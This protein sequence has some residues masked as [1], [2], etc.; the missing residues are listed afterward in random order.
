MERTTI[1]PDL[2]EDNPPEDVDEPE[3]KKKKTSLFQIHHAK[4]VHESGGNVTAMG[5]ILLQALG[6]DPGSEAGQNISMALAPP[7]L[8]PTTPPTIKHTSKDNQIMLK[9][10][11]G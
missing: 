6:I 2:P 8:P 10:L 9:G 1:L 11:K 5:E 3:V 7:P 4:K